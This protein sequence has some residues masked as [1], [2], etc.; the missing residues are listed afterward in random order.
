MIIRIH[1]ADLAKRRKHA[2]MNHQTALRLWLSNGCQNKPCRNIEL[3]SQRLLTHVPLN[4]DEVKLPASVRRPDAREINAT[5][6]FRPVY[7]RGLLNDG[8]ACKRFVP[9]VIKNWNSSMPQYIYIYI[10]TRHSY[11]RKHAL[12][13][14][15]VR[16]W[17]LCK[18]L[19][20][21]QIVK[22]Y[23]S[24]LNLRLWP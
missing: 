18:K 7:C 11:A 17:A 14:E 24:L 5:P 8:P 16:H 21:A 13:H 4:D 1:N 2:T 3:P 9:S 6:P 19:T 15:I 22:R 12:V 20:V 23:R 10:Y